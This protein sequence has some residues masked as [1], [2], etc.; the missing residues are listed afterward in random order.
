MSDSSPCPHEFFEREASV[1][2]EGLCPL[3][4]VAETERLRTRLRQL[5]RAAEGYM[6]YHQ[7]KFYADT[8]SKPIGLWPEIEAAKK[9]IGDE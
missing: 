8:D 3:C 7:E 4:L 6:R 2:T 1:A 5:A 9:A